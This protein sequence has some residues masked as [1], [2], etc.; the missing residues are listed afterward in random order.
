VNPHSPLLPTDSTRWG[1]LLLDLASK[2]ILVSGTHGKIFLSHDLGS[3]ANLN[4][5][6]SISVPA[7]DLIENTQRYYEVHYVLLPI[8]TVATVVK[9]MYNLYCGV[10]VCDSNPHSQPFLASF[11]IIL[12]AI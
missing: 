1:K 11:L 2:V 7:A 6:R 9:A 3:R 12:S 4:T 5:K 8:C 10:F